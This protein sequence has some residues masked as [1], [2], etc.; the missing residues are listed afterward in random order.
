[1][2]NLI[3]RGMAAASLF[4]LAGAATAQPA[5]T[6]APTAQPAVPATPAVK[7]PSTVTPTELKPAIAKPAEAAKPVSPFVL[8]F[9]MKDIDGKEQDLAQYKGKVIMVINVASQCGN[10]P[11]YENLEKLY[12]EKK[13][14]GF[15][16]LAFPA[17]NFREQ[18][19]GSDSEIKTF[20]TTGKFHVTFPLFSK[21]SVK[22]KDQ[23]ELYKTISAQ[24]KPIG[25]DPEWNFQ[26]FLVD[27]SGNVV[28]RFDPKTDPM[29]AAVTR[30]IDELLAA[31]APEIAK[32]AEVAKPAG[33]AKPAVKPAVKP[34]EK[35]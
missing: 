2:S 22:G 23:V 11:Q 13:D 32:P 1:M 17:N 15:V 12:Q 6:P 26:K 18:E 25:G 27:K 29:N 5:T 33:A 34:V 3:V 20:C 8:G 14:K 9:K 30:K 16:I 35:K 19:P 28:A 31:K 21:I 4:I 24:P 10:T 7:V